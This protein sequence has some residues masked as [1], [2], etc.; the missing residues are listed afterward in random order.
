[1]RFENLTELMVFYREYIRGKGFQTKIKGV[2]LKTEPEDVDV[3]KPD[4][5]WNEYGYRCRLMCSKKGN[6]LSRKKD[7]KLKARI[8]KTGCPTKLNAWRGV[9]G[10]WRITKLVLN[11]NHEIEPENSRF[12]SN[13]REICTRDKGRLITN[14]LVGIPTIKSY[15]SLVMQHDGF[16]KTPMLEHD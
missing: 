16:E 4:L 5:L 14:K 15:L 11:H 13:Y 6:F 9:D 8:M 12:M 3:S 10:V 7:P 1:M 2:D